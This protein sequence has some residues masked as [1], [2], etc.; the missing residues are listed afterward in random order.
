MR[1]HA[2]RAVRRLAIGL[3]VGAVSVGSAAAQQHDMQ[4]A[5]DQQQYPTLRLSGFG[6][7]NFAAMKRVDGP[8]LYGAA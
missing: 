7:V 3:L 6:D 1:C 8:R 4:P 2:I 5:P